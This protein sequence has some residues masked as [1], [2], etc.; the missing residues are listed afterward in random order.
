MD[1]FTPMETSKDVFGAS[2]EARKEG[3]KGEGGRRGSG[4]HYPLLGSHE[5]QVSFLQRREN[6]ENKAVFISAIKVVLSHQ[7]QRRK[8][9]K[10]CF[11]L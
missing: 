2:K 7:S 3:G 1:N 9:Q 4:F 8:R 6:G 5:L 10:D 11:I